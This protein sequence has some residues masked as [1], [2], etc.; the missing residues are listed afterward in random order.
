MS[1]TVR[2]QNGT[3]VQGAT[4]Y[5]GLSSATTAADGTYT[6][7]AGPGDHYVSAQ[8][9]GYQSAPSVL[10]PVPPAATGV[11]FV[12]LVKDQVIRGRV[13]NT[14]GQPLEDAYVSASSIVCGNWG[15]GGTATTADG[16]YTL[17]VPSGVYHVT[18]S[19][20]GY[21]PAPPELARALATNLQAPDAVEVNFTLTP[22]ANSIRGTV[23]DSLGRPL[24]NASV[25][26]SACGL[27]YGTDT[28]VSGAYTLTVSAN[29]FSV[30]ASKS[31]YTSPPAQS[32]SVPPDASRVD[33]ALTARVTYTITGRVT[34]PQ[35]NAVMDVWVGTESGP[36]YDSDNTDVDGKYALH[37][38]AGSYQVGAE[39]DGWSQPALV[40]VSVPPNRSGVDFV[41]SP[42]SLSIKGTV[43]DAAGHGVTDA[44]VCPTLS[45]ETS[46]FFCKRPY[47]NGAY[48][49]LLPAGTYRV[50]ASASCYTSA[51]I[52]NVVLPPSR[53]GVDLTIRLRDQLIAGRVTDS[54]GQPLCGASVNAKD[55]FTD[56]DS[57]SRNGRYALNLP[58]GTYKVSAS[59]TGYGAAVEKTV[60]V[61]PFAI[62]TDFV[63]GTP[64][65]TIQGMVRDRHGAAI[66]GAS[67]F[68]SS[69]SGTA[70]A[71]TG[72]DG[73][74][75]LKVL[76][77]KWNVSAS[78]AGYVGFPGVRTA[79]V[80]PSQTGIDFMLVVRSEVK[81]DYLPLIVKR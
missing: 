31:G 58:A 2:D 75:T 28:D 12:L 41:I 72:A 42:L 45:G 55:G 52:Q 77:G 66:A 14:Q 44:W 81:S 63:L 4:I 21:V 61:P 10:V 38:T 36:D 34:D 74:Y 78:K 67:V 7:M 48:T 1:G 13:V 53:T 24:E 43:R 47:Y 19:S 80:P 54:A 40:A 22:L 16:A 51:T 3:P 15:S 65:N 49:E 79:T 56:S 17:T 50:Y 35:G 46:S 76:D 5:G 32:V 73:K 70:S 37:V 26:A 60:T 68:A 71:A 39:K 8:K 20:D 9:S 27:T 29:T 33:F 59:K 69:T 6:T 62:G 30:S 64:P 57:T 25:Y 11:D 18:A 23:R